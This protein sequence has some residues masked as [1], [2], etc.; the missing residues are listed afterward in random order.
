MTMSRAL[1]QAHAKLD[2]SECS[3]LEEEGWLDRRL[4][5]Y[6]KL[7]QLVDPSGGGFAQVVED[8][9]QVQQETEECQKDLRRLGWTG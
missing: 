5:E 9:T 3:L 1:T 7:L 2:Q 6:H 8:W 4:D